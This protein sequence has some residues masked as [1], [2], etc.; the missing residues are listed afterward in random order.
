MEQTAY[1]TDDGVSVIIVH[2]L[3]IALKRWG[4]P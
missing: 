1:L 2:D 4:N 3:R